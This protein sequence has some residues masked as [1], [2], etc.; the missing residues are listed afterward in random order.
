MQRS[1]PVSARYFKEIVSIHRRSSLNFQF[2]IRT[3]INTR[4]SRFFRKINSDFLK[5]TRE[6]WAEDAP[7]DTQRVINQRRSL[8]DEGR[9]IISYA[10]ID[11]C[12]FREI[13]KVEVE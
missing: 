6:E 7:S 11:Y 9:S 12:C 5:K 4:K 2:E 3:F 10:E 1:E 8:A 13:C